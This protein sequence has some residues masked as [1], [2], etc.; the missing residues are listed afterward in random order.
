MRMRT[1]V[2]MGLA[3][4]MLACATV[5]AQRPTPA[6]PKDSPAAPSP[7]S[8]KLEELRAGM[9]QMIRDRGS[10]EVTHRG[11]INVRVRV[12][13]I[14]DLERALPVLE[15]VYELQPGDVN[16]RWIDREEELKAEMTEALGK[17]PDPVT[18][19]QELRM[20]DMEKKLDRVLKALESPKRAGGQ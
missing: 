16:M 11:A 14:E 17:V 8:L 9:E 18:V 1:R 6:L 12:E 15:R 5:W 13:S 4:V 19:S 3:I 7:R 20:R 2:G 10:V